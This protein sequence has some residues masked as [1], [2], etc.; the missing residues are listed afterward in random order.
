[1][2]F[3]TYKNAMNQIDWLYVEY[4]LKQLTEG[5]LSRRSVHTRNTRADDIMIKIQNDIVLSILDRVTKE[6]G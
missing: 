2:E 6:N 4:T 1:M 5:K 3:N